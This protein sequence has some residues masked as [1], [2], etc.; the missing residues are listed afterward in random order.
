MS[1]S[2][3]QWFTRKEIMD[4]VWAIDDHGF[5]SIY[6]VTGKKK[7]LLIDTGFGIGNLAGLTASITNLPVTVVNTHGHPDHAGGDYR[8]PA[9]H[10]SAEDLSLLDAC[11]CKE[12]REWDNEHFKMSEYLPDFS[13][14][15]WLDA[16]LNLLPTEIL[17]VKPGD[18]FDLGDRTIEVI[19]IPGHTPGSICLLDSENKILFS[20]DSA[21]TGENWLHLSESLCLSDYYNNLK[22]LDSI[23]NKF[24]FIFPGHGKC[25]ANKGIIKIL[26]DGIGDIL[27]GKQTGKTY[28]T[29]AGDGLFCRF[30]N[31]AVVYNKDRL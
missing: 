12:E 19:G 23:S 2:Y 31:C 26:I 11:Y 10:I 17:P 27:E 8:F 9:V 6:L 1:D 18:V 16:S 13:V 24:D 3:F 28:H 7:S 5:D 30:K 21:K 25:L 29:F 20:G 4:G 14:E 22:K 15:E